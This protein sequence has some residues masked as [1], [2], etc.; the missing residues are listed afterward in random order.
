[1][2]TFNLKL[3]FSKFAVVNEDISS[4]NSKKILEKAISDSHILFDT[5]DNTRHS[6]TAPVRSP[7]RL[8]QPYV[9]KFKNKME[10]KF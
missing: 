7:F 3:T 9:K 1:V 8:G 5:D 10:T 2:Q 6:C 4:K